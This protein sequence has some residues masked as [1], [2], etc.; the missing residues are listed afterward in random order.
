MSVPAAVRILAPA[1]V[2]LWLRVLRRRPDGFHELDTLFQAVDLC[3]EVEVSRR[4][5]TGVGL[6]V[7]GADLGPARENLAH[8]AALAFLDAAGRSAGSDRVEIRLRKRIPAG[9]GLGGGS[10]DAAAVLRC[11]SALWGDPLPPAVLAEVG[12][13][14]GS[15]VAFFL[16]RRPLARGRGRGEL[17]EALQPLPQGHLVLVLPPVHVATGPAYGAL[18]RHRALHGA[19]GGGPP[20]AGV[21]TW[22]DLA[23]A[24][25]NDFELVV[26][27]AH[28]PVAA[29]LAALRAAGARPALLS[30]SGGACFG[31]FPDEDRARAAAAEIGGR[32]GWDAVLVRTLAAFPVPQPI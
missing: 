31:A 11:V 17:L 30:G 5:G 8:R 4:P 29:S 22:R 16:G 3:D 1:K 32:L 21:P 27:G 28:P 14:L 2:N 12:A 24:A 13:S 15:D 19:D 26:P 20:P 10:S 25:V 23:E 6:T 7:E 9:A 18:A